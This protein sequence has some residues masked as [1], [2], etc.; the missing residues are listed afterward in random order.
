MINK[1]AKYDYKLSHKT[2]AGIVLKG[3][4]VKSILNGNISL[5]ESYV[6]IINDEVFLLGAHISELNI[7][8]FESDVD[9]M[10]PK[11]LLLHKKQINKYKKLLKEPG[12]TLI[13]YDI[14]IT[15]GKFKGDLYLGKGKKDYDKRNAIKERDL[16][17]SHD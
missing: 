3:P 5:K 14:H 7:Q 13:L 2:E 8:R 17:R 4:E 6:K 1:K 12:T 10:R 9:S 15:N 11:K 16:Q